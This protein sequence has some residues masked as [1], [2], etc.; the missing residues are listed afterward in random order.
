MCV[1]FITFNMNPEVT[2]ITLYCFMTGFRHIPQ[3]NRVGIVTL[4]FDY[5]F[6]LR[7]YDLV[8]IYSVNYFV[9]YYQDLRVLVVFS[10]SIYLL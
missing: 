10:L 2:V 7:I 8:W 4:T 9:T 3:G 6:W 1:D 5:D